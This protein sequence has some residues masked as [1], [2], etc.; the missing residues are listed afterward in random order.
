MRFLSSGESH[1]KAISAIIDG[2][3]SGVSIDF[4]FLNEE[5][6]RRQKGFGRGK[7]MEIEKDTIEI[8]SGI[9]FG[10]SLG[11]PISFLIYNK[12]W[13]SWKEKLSIEPLDQNNIIKDSKILNPRP[14]HAD[15]PGYIKYRFDDIRNVI[16]RSSAR[17]TAA[18]VAVGGFAKIFLKVFGINIYSIVNRIG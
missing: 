15:F 9:R 1:G 4:E 8:L 6:K 16:E 13:E 5:L 17:E 3:P 14:G 12:D 2:F 7:R 11:T 18:R 10:I